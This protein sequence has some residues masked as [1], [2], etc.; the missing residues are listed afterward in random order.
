MFRFFSAACLLVI[1]VGCGPRTGEV[2]GEVTFKGKPI[3]GG[4]LTFRPAD[5]S[6]NSVSYDL[7]RDGKFKVVLPVGDVA[8][9]IDNR[10]FEP[11]PA[12]VPAI[13]P[14]MNLPPDVIKGMQASSKESSKVSDRW[15]KLPERYYQV[16]TSNTKIAV[17]GGK[18]S[19]T[20]EFKE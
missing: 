14:G 5:E 16:E 1:A 17:K 2:S 19:E 10:E 20:I 12:T 3:P 9:S 8:I 15:V 18:Q 4:I 6:Q 11:R 13:P 7:Q